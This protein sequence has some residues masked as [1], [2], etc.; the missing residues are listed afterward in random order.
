MALNITAA[1]PFEANPKFVAGQMLIRDGRKADALRHFHAAAS[2][3]PRRPE[4]LIALSQAFYA[5]DQ[6]ANARRTLEQLLDVQPDHTRARQ[7]LQFLDAQP[8][9]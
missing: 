4:Y 9:D 8:A 7:M 2:M 3:A 1:F 5:N 6:R